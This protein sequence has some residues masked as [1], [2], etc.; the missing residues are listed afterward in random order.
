MTYVEYKQLNP[1]QRFAHNFK[2]FILN[3]PHA[4]A[5]FFKAIGHAIVSFFT[6][7]GKGFKNYGVTFVKGDWATKLSYLIFGIGDIHKG[8]YY[9][10]IL[11]FLTEVLYALYM[12][13]FGWTYLQKFTTLGTV[14]TTQD[15]N[16]LGMPVTVYGDNSML[17]LL[18]S[19]L[20][21]VIT[22]L[23]FAVYIANIKDAYRHQVMR[24]EGEKPTSLKHD[25]KEFLDGK[26]HIT[27]LSFP[28]LMIGIFNIMPMI[29]MIL[30]AF[31]NYDQQHL[32]PGTLFTWVGFDNFSSLFN[33]VDSATKATTF[34]EL[35]KWTLIWAVV[36]TFTNYILG[37]VVALMINKK[38]IKFKAL[39]RTLFVIAIAVPQFVSLLLMN[40]MLQTNGAI[41]IVLSYFNGGVNPEIQFLNSTT[42]MAR[43]TVIIVNLW[44]GI[45]YTILSM[46][47]ILMNIPEDLYE[48][49]RIDG[50]GP[51]KTFTKITLPYM[52]FVTTPQLIT[53][54]VGNI[55]N[56]NVIY[57]LTGGGPSTE[58]FYQAG[59]TDILVTWLFNLTM[60]SQ[61][62]GLAAAIGILVFIVCATLSLLIYNNS[63][64]MKDEEAF[65]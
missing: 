46:S 54:F 47:G 28:T 60:G 10:G 53:Q 40:Q 50:A 36:A 58:Q 1:F 24:A 41:N 8:K 44:V 4:L 31:T 22:I 12:I 51:V 57:L 23:V 6:G 55:N 20:S 14:A 29:F 7:I 13:F 26:Y 52:I 35:T 25:V 62:Y 30:I 17:I 43:L 45:P 61:D 65:S 15:F 19:V 2:K 5:K 42:L 32:P 49:A 38:G 3:I 63:K 39:W 56:F 37:M 16:E 64:S 21:I 48:S 18:Y 11:F 59:R 9:K 33:F 34:I 27:L